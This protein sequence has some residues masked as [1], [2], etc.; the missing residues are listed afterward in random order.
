MAFVGSAA[1]VECHAD[2]FDAWSGSHHDRAMQ[3]ASDETVLGDFDDASF[4]SFPVVTRF[5]R[6]GGKFVVHT[7]GPAGAMGDFEVKYTF[8]VEP[9]QQYLVEFPGGRVQSLTIAWD[10]ERKRWFDL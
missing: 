4:A 8:G 6:R 9:L 7:E 3:V 10:T 5:F 1:C 2:A